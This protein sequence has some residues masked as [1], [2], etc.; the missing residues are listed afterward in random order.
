[1]VKNNIHNTHT[2]PHT[3]YPIVTKRFLFFSFEKSNEI[4]KAAAALLLRSQ[5]SGGRV[6]VG[7]AHPAGF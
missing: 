4:E 1:V 6:K 5:L 7:A 3:F 2:H